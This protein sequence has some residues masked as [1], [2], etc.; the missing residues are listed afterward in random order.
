MT[1]FCVTGF[2]GSGKSTLAKMLSESLHN[3]TLIHSDEFMYE[4][5]TYF[6]KDFER[7]FGLPIFEGNNTKT[8]RKPVIESGI[9]EWRAYLNLVLPYID[10]CIE[11][12]LAA[13][14][15]TSMNAVIDW[16]HLPLTRVWSYSQCRIVI[17]TSDAGTRRNQLFQRMLSREQ[18]RQYSSEYLRRSIEMKDELDSMSLGNLEDC[19]VI[20]NDYDKTFQLEAVRIARLFV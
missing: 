11:E 8:F 7:I 12:K 18:Y 14:E 17:A 3:S 15:A 9:R 20:N 6:Q 2:S 10:T 16:V 1:I 19:I 4:S 5:V 13:V